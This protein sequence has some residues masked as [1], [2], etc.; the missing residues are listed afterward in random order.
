[1]NKTIKILSVILA[2]VTLSTLCGCNRVDEND[3]TLDLDAKGAELL[4]LAAFDDTLAEIN[5]KVV[6]ALIGDIGAITDVKAYFAES[7]AAAEALYLIYCEDIQN[8]EHIKNLLAAYVEDQI[9]GFE[10]YNP[11]EVPKLK[12]AVIISRGHYVLYCAA[13]DASALPDVFE[14]YF[15]G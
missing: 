14:G 15:K 7:G 12:D 3:V 9:S 1:M 2:L 8:V 13:K 6:S 11:T 5:G 10:S 4:A